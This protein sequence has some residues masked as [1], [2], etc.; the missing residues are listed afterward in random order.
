M[1]VVHC[2]AVYYVKL[3]AASACT[4]SAHDLDEI[5][6]ILHRKALERYPPFNDHNHRER[7]SVTCF[8]SRV[9]DSVE[10]GMEATG[11]DCVIIRAQQ[12]S[13]VPL[14]EMIK[15]WPM[16]HAP[17][18][19]RERKLEMTLLNVDDKPCI[20]RQKITWRPG[21]NSVLC[22]TTNALITFFSRHMQAWHWHS[23]I[24]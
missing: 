2:R 17:S 4:S 3:C 1:S 9:K 7:Q 18:A 15:G 12:R 5:V 11:W 21:I 22:R 6:L 23:K 20:Y 19:S 14:V 13:P 10:K 16:I 24:G 8:S